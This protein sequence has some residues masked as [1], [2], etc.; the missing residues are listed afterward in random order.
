MFFMFFCISF[1]YTILRDTKDSLIVTAPNSGAEAIPFLK[2]WCVVPSAIFLMV[3]YT[4][5][6]NRLTKESLFY[7]VLSP[8]LAFFMLFAFVLYPNAHL[9]HPVESANYLASLLPDTAGF[10]GVIAIY[11]NWSY[12][13]FYILSEMWGSMVLSLMFWGFANDITKTSEAKR[14]YALFGIG[15]NVALIFSGQAIKW[16]SIQ[17]EGRTYTDSLQVMM[18]MVLAMGLGVMYIYY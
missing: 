8:F 7:T 4:S 2:V 9:I 1:I 12:A 18:S 15:A 6:A 5:L 14:F 13:L 16:A 3:V 10:R 11:R 17:T